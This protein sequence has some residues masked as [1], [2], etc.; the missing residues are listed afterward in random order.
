MPKPMF[1]RPPAPAVRVQPKA[2]PAAPQESPEV[3]EAKAAVQ[4]FEQQ[5]TILHHMQA[6][7]DQAFPDASEALNE[8][9]RQEDIVA[10]SIKKAKPL[11]AA[12]KMT[13]G[14]FYAQ[15]KW[16]K[17]HYDEE[18]VTQIFNRLE[19]APQVFMEMLRSGVVKTVELAREPAMAWFAQNPAYAHIFEDAFRSDTEMPTAVTVPKI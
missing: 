5:I 4:Y 1:G 11:V 3:A 16:E 14:D 19:N 12:A 7:W 9:K 6:D 10:D 8:V 2:A 13:I 15:R 18:V 17:A